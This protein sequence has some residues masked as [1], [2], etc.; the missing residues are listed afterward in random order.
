MWNAKFCVACDSRL[1]PDIVEMKMLARTAQFSLQFNKEKVFNW[2]NIKLKL[3]WVKNSKIDLFYLK[4]LK[5]FALFRPTKTQTSPKSHKK[6]HF[7]NRIWVKRE[8][9]ILFYISI[10]WWLR[11]RQHFIN[12][13]Q[14]IKSINRLSCLLSQ[15]NCLNAEDTHQHNLCESLEPKMLRFFVLFFNWSF[16][17][18]P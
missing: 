18:D 1:F 10:S 16:S 17:A 13:I 14:N 5:I 11:A 12:F 2:S 8:S 7:A 15:K 6:V 9:K 4:L 3:V